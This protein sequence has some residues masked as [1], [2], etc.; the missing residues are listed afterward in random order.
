MR[1]SIRPKTRQSAVRKFK[2]EKKIIRKS[3]RPKTRQSVVWKF[4]REKIL[5]GTRK[6]EVSDSSA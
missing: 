5:D 4:K 1:K 2:R 3:I 6:E